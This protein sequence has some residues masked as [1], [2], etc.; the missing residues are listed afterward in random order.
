MTAVCLDT[1]QITLV[2]NNALQKVYEKY[3]NLYFV[4]SGK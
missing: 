2:N 1:R 4:L 3:V